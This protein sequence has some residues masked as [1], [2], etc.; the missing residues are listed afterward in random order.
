MNRL[1]HVELAGIHRLASRGSNTNINL[2]PV[3]VPRMVDD[4]REDTIRDLLDENDAEDLKQMRREM[5]ELIEDT[6]DEREE[7]LV[8]YG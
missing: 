2:N 1:I 7:E 6:S 4:V 5:Q 3:D 8:R